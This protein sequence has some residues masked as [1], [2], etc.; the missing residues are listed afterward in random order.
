M[1]RRT[2]WLSG[3]AGGL[4]C[5]GRRLYLRPAVAED[6]S[7]WATVRA[8]SREH[9]VPWEP[10]WPADALSR[11]H[12]RRR[13]REQQRE[14]RAGTGYALL[15]FHREDDRL[16][17]GLTVGN[18]RRGV[19]QSATL[20]YW[21]AAGEAGRGFMTEAVGAVLPFLFGTLNLHRVEAA[22]L[23]E[24]AASQAVLRANGFAEEGL[25]RKYLCINGTWRDHVL[26]GLL[27]EDHYARMR[28][29]AAGE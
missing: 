15:I 8:A 5:E 13:L 4:R 18:I 12:F 6:W 7:Q 27:A 29:A 20:G 23:P 22:C 9:L 24:N 14:Q 26:F 17:G 3:A 2:D 1:F 21:M 11:E 28:L 25:A 16:L 19:A 10:A